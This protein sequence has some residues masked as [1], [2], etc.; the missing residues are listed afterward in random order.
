MLERVISNTR[1][2][3]LGLAWLVITIFSSAVFAQSAEPTALRDF[4]STPA[5]NPFEERVNDNFNE[6]FVVSDASPHTIKRSQT[7]TDEGLCG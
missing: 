6:L 3:K 2:L 7:F 1:A 4:Y 5:L